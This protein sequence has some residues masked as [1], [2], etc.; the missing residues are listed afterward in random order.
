[1]EFDGQPWAPLC[2]IVAGS[3]ARLSYPGRSSPGSF[4]LSCFAA[5]FNYETVGTGGWHGAP[6][7]LS[8]VRFSGSRL[9]SRFSTS[10]S[11]LQGPRPLL[12]A[13]VSPCAAPFLIS[14]ALQCWL[15]LLLHTPSFHINY[16]YFAA[17]LALYRRVLWVLFS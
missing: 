5:P 4:P 6:R 16:F 7:F 1:M 15:T 2:P 12:A 9:D 17:Q 10:D 3:F 11:P 13:D 8:L 14:L